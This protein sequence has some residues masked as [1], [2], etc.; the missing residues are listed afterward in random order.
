MG[1]K[2]SRVD[3][4][5]L[6]TSRDSD[7]S[8]AAGACMR[9]A[10]ARRSA[11]SRARESRRCWPALIERLD[12]CAARAAR[13]RDRD[14]EP[15][16]RSGVVADGVRCKPRGI[17]DDACRAYTRRYDNAESMARLP[18]LLLA[19][20]AVAVAASR[21]AAAW[22]SWTFL[23][24]AA[25]GRGGGRGS[26]SV[27]EPMSPAS[28]DLPQS[29]ACG[30]LTQVRA[31]AN[32]TS[33]LRPGVACCACRDLPHVASIAQHAFCRPMPHPPR[34]NSVVRSRTMAAAPA[35]TQAR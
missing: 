24:P 6:R 18:A 23:Q 28:R 27:A 31:T 7:R 35:V 20:V 21:G 32:L 25:Q 33:Q 34:Q 5:Y 29:P 16:V 11:T 13:R 3:L 2:V 26:G 14:S 17:A 22:P 19:A 4:L 12:Q 15:R 8:I 10:R 9:Q 30:A 1:L